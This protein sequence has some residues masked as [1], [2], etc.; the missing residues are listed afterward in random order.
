MN[1][2]VPFE[3]RH[4][5]LHTRIEDIIVFGTVV[6]YACKATDDYAVTYMSKNVESQLGYT[7]EDFLNDSSFWYSHIHPDDRETIVAALSQLVDDEHSVHQYRFRHKNGTYR[8]MQDELRLVFADDGSP[9]EIMGSWTDITN[10]KDLEQQLTTAQEIAHLGSWYWDIHSCTLR[11]S[12]ETYR[13]FNLSPDEYV[14]TYDSYL[15]KVHPA[16]RTQVVQAFAS[17]CN[18]V[19]SYSINYRIH[20]P[21]GEVRHVRDKGEVRFS[22][23]GEPIGVSGAIH[24]V[25]DLKRTEIELKKKESRLVRLAYYDQLTDLPNRNLFLERL[26]PSLLLAQQR[27]TRVGVLSIDID[28][29]RKVNDIL[30]YRVGDELLQLVA[31]RLKDTLAETETLARLSEEK[32]VALITDPELLGKIAA[33]AQNI[34]DTFSQPFTTAN[35]RQLFLTASIGISL[36]PEDAAD[37]EGLLT[38]GDVAMSAAKK[39]HHSYRFYSPAMDARAHELLQLENDLR[40]AIERDELV[41]HYQPQVDIQTGRLL[42]MEALLRWQH[43]Q[44]GLI[45]PNDFIPLAEESGLILQIGDWV[46]RTACFQ[47]REF[48]DKGLE[49]FVMCVNVSA[50]QLKK[51]D[52]SDSVISAL[53]DSG[54]AADSLEL[55]ITE[56]TVIEDSKETAAHLS[57]LRKLGVRVAIDDFGTGYSSLALLNRLPLTTLKIDRG[58]VAGILSS[59]YDYVIIEAIQT[60]ARTLNLKV[61]AEGIETEEQRSLLCCLGC[62]IGQGFFFSRPQPAA[63]LLCFSKTVDPFANIQPIRSVM[64]DSL[65]GTL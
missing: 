7:P 19:A 39:D 31:R 24:D 25:S 26:D 20:R 8:W 47:A 40:K 33:V 9:V 35:E 21:D 36:Y 44:M 32:F 6:L 54:L 2:L 18:D 28:N 29:F 17:A 45:Q 57:R 52:F 34:Q 4:Q 48:L 61:V 23:K 13:I 62:K 60:L 37:A 1:S 16:D 46:L 5:A 56:S 65:L 38:C 58:F 30:G 42:G 50:L 10:T 27:G 43:G 14:P 22:E 11:W 41:L 15:L 53:E 63:E 3:N 12:D 55:E 59:Q 64:S 51:T 49:P